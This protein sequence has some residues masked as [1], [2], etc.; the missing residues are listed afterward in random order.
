MT[1][2]AAD[3]AIARGIVLGTSG[4]SSAEKVT[5]MSLKNTYSLLGLSLAASW[6]FAGLSFYL[7]SRTAVDWFSRSGAVMCLISVAA[8]FALVKV[9]QR[10]LAK[11][12][13]DHERSAREKKDESL[14][15]SGAFMAVLGSPPPNENH[16]LT[17][18]CLHS[19]MRAMRAVSIRSMTLM[20]TVSA[21]T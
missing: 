20:L 1:G 9:H 13:R 7:S 3:L 10:D 5:Q 2:P 21:A 17:M 4:D 15:L 16:F 12:L 18:L 19:V 8:N 14:A 11:I 6:L